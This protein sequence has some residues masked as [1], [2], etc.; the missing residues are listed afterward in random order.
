MHEDSMVHANFSQR[1]TP[2]QPLNP[3]APAH[4][5]YFLDATK[6]GIYYRWLHRGWKVRSIAATYGCSVH[7]VNAVLVEKVG[8]LEREVAALR[9][10]PQ[11]PAPGRRVIAMPK[12]A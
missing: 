12:A 2:R 9:R 3:L 1:R 4:S 7:D 6:D 8:N 5:I 10:P 11:P